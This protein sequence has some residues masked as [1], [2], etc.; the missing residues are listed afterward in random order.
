MFCAARVAL[1]MKHGFSWLLHCL[2]GAPLLLCM[3]FES[4]QMQLLNVLYKVET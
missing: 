3:P 4:R 2:L 1:H